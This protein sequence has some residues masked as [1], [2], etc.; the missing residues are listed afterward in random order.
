MPQ[1]MLQQ[2]FAPTSSEFATQ[3]IRLFVVILFLSTTTAAQTNSWYP[4]GPTG[5]DVSSLTP[6]LGDTIYASIYQG[7]LYRSNDAG[8]TWSALSVGSEHAAALR[9][10]TILS[11]YVYSILRSTDKGSSWSTVVNGQNDIVAIAEVSEGIALCCVYGEGFLRSTDDGQSWTPANDGLIDE[12]V[13]VLAVDSTGTVYAGTNSNPATLYR[14]TNRGLTWTITS[15]GPPLPYLSC[16]TIT[17]T[18]TLLTGSWFGSMARSTDAGTS[19]EA[20]IAGSVA[21]DTS[22][23]SLASGKNGV[24]IAAMDK[25][26]MGSADDGK[27][28]HSVPMYP[29]TP[30]VTSVVRMAGGDLLAG[31]W[32][33]GLFRSSDGGTTW[34]LSNDRLRSYWTI[35]LAAASTNLIL[36]A[37]PMGMFRSTDDGDNWTRLAG[38]Y[39]CSVISVSEGR[40]GLVYATTQDG[41]VLKSLDGGANWSPVLSLGWYGL[42]PI[43]MAPDSTMWIATAGG[44]RRSTDDGGTWLS[45]GRLTSVNAMAGGD[46]WLYA[47]TEIGVYRTQISDTSWTLCSGISASSRDIAVPPDGDAFAATAAGLYRSTDHGLH[48]GNVEGLPSGVGFNQIVL[49]TR[50]NFYVAGL[51]SGVFLSHSAGAG[52]EPASAGLPNGDIIC[53]AVTRY[54]SLL[55]GPGSAGLFRFTE[56]ALSVP[57]AAGQAERFQLLPNYPNPFNPTTDIRYQ[58]PDAGL[59]R[60]AVY[61]MLGREVRVLVNERKAPGNYEVRFDASGLATGVYFYR[62]SAGNFVLTRRLILLK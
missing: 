7:G 57:P 17:P 33:F 36:V 49:A 4:I 28:W 29:E 20:V 54:G 14:S 26:L 18:G 62:M 52:W 8:H 12:N 39:P 27:T 46:G 47:A 51:G 44:L 43:C 13:Q 40:R 42:G 35:A 15:P 10:G 37:T 32:D 38:F 6:G 50:S 9:S 11:S 22:F 56:N 23:R 25:G 21:S 41:Y 16:M 3:I 24:V 55:A 2:N 48:W 34:E 5:G 30:V 61:D 60:L 1:P 45:S 19:W 31:T 53:L 58:V 59:V